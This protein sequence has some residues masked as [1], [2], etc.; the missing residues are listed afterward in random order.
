MALVDEE[1]NGKRTF[2]YPSKLRRLTD[3]IYEK[4]VSL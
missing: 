3:D 1:I 2:N 4:E